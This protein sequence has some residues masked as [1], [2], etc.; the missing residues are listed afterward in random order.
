MIQQYSEDPTAS[1]WYTDGS[2]TERGMG[3]SVY[4]WTSKKMIHEP[5]GNDT[6]STVE[7]L[8]LVAI[9]RALGYI[10]T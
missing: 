1:L 3:A 8:E 9:N 7:V 4:E 2:G 10:T 6:I 5:I